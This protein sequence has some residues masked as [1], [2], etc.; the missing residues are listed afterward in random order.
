MGQ[1]VL[2]HEVHSGALFAN[3]ER[4]RQSGAMYWG[5]RILV[6]SLHVT[7]GKKDTKRG[8]GCHDQASQAGTTR[9][10][11]AGLVQQ[12]IY[13]LANRHGAPKE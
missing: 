8:A 11:L 12:H 3:Q 9:L 6:S 5:S 7:Q 1:E 2:E 10:L 4:G 13:F